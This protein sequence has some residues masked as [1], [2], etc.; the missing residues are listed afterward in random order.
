MPIDPNDDDPARRDRQAR[1][2][3]EGKIR[4][5]ARMNADYQEME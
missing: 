3:Q 1:I 5:A 4:R 2:L